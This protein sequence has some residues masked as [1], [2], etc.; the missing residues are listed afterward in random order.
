MIIDVLEVVFISLIVVIAF[1]DAVGS[2]KVYK[3][4]KDTGEF[5]ENDYFKTAK[6]AF[7]F[8]ITVLAIFLTITIS[9]FYILIAIFGV[10][11]FLFFYIVKRRE[12]SN[13]YKEKQEDI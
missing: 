2:Y 12:F 4:L 11:A 8:V 10:I 6:V 9:V 5:V 1:L 13:Y 3:H 7:M